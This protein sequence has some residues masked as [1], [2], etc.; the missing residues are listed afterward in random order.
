MTFRQIAF[1]SAEYQQEC[2]LRQEILRKPLGLNLYDEDLERERDQR[3][4]GLFDAAGTLV[5][6]AVAAPLSARQARIRQMAVARRC[7]GQG[8]GRRILAEVER[9]LAG[10]GFIHLVLHARASA[11]G[12]YEKQGYAAAGEQFV[13]VTIPHVK[14]E[15]RLAATGEAAK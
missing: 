15:K 4:F 13:E 6:C 2:A 10:D 8:Q 11:I 1:G 12:F 14:M 9:R 3:H 7:Q 5:A